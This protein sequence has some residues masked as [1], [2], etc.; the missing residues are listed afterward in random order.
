[1]LLFA[2]IP[3]VIL[4]DFRA[5]RLEDLLRRAREGCGFACRGNPPVPAE[6]PGSPMTAVGLYSP[7]MPDPSDIPDPRSHRWRAM[8]GDVQLWIPVTV[9]VGGLLLLKWVA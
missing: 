3:L 5:H 6:G 9:L 4:Y 8:V 1:M 2:E 7:L